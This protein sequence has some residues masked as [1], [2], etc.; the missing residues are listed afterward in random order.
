MSKIEANGD[1]TAAIARVAEAAREVQAASMA[2][3]AHF[4]EHAG[5]SPTLLLA[6]LAAGMAELQEARESFDAL[7]AR[8]TS[9]N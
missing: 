6:R 8:R 7:L 3:E 4:R 2:L 1:E 9:S 5:E